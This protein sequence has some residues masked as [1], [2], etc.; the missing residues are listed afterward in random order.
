M[1]N[2]FEPM[3]SAVRQKQTLEIVLKTLRGNFITLMLDNSFAKTMHRISRTRQIR[4]KLAVRV[5]QH[6][7]INRLD[8]KVVFDILLGNKRILQKVMFSDEKRF[9]VDIDEA[10]LGGNQQHYVTLKNEMIRPL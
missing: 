10:M 3:K 6:R 8:T 7:N 4:G 2:S 5:I 1:T 9:E